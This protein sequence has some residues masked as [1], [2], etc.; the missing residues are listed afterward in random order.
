MATA[1]TPYIEHHPGDLITAEDWNEMQ[2]DVRQD[3]AA[4]IAASIAGVKD[5]DHARA[6][7][8]SAACRL[9]S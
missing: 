2:V 3:M 5:V 4:Q 9:P 6:P 1:P 8:S 7:I